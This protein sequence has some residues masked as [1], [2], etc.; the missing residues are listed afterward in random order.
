MAPVFGWTDLGREVVRVETED[1]GAEGTKRE[2]EVGLEEVLVVGFEVLP[3]VCLD[4]LDL[5]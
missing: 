3:L 2:E 1:L 5:V 4:F